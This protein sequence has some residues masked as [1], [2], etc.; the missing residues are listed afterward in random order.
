MVLKQYVFSL[1]TLSIG[2]LLLFKPE[3]YL[4]IIYKLSMQEI[5]LPINKQQILICKIAGVGGIFM[6]IFVLWMSFKH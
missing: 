1:L 2:L 6:G 4:K 5:K 3:K